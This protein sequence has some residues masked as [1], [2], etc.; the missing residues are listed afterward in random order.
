MFHA[1][2]QGREGRR[3]SRSP[4]PGRAAR[5]KFDAGYDWSAEQA[6]QVEKAFTIQRGQGDRTPGRGRLRPHAAV[7]RLGVGERDEEE[8]ERGDRRPHGRGQRLP[9]VGPVAPGRQGRDARH[10][11][12]PAGRRQG[13]CED[14]ADGRTSGLTSQSPTTAPASRAASR[15]TTTASRSRPTSRPTR[16]SPRR[17][18]AVPLKIGQRATDRPGGR[19]RARRPA[20]LRPPVHRHRRPAG[21]RVAADGRRARQ[22]GRQADPAGSRRTL[23]LVARRSRRR[24]PD[25]DRSLPQ[26][27]GGGGRDQEP[28][29]HRPRDERAAPTPSRARSCCSAATTTSAA[30]R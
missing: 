11:R 25:R 22:T 19:R 3:R 24:L 18:T 26:G 21:S 9:R 23:Q 27:A 14:A 8:R 12:L 1:P 16:S 29:H 7:R 10:Q 15:S 28:G 17:K 13:R 6:G 2:A 4:W 20:H 5:L 30:T